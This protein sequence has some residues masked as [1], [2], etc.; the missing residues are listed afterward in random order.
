MKKQ[1]Q[2][3]VMRS[4]TRANKLYKKGFRIIPKLMMQLVRIMWSCEVNEACDIGEGVVFWHR[5]MGTVVHA[6]AKIGAGTHILQNVTI[7]VKLGQNKAPV[8]GKNCI[9]SAG[10]CVIGDITI[11]DG[12]IV[13][14]NSVVIKDV[15]ANCIVAGNPAKILKTDISRENY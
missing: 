11:G 3:V 8:I 4:Y 2:D 13:A 7:G 5:G 12:S 10:S 15:P 6:D 1:K 14:N 9:I